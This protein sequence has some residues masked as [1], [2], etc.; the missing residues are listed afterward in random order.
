[1]KHQ[2]I[3]IRDDNGTEVLAQVPLIISASRA[4]DIPAFYPDWFFRQ[5]D[6]G[7][8]GILSRGRI[9]MFQ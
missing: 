9:A 3:T 4:T 2:T 1:M 8:G 7:Y 6:K 5:L